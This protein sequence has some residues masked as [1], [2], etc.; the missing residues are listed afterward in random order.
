M[1]YR[2]FKFGSLKVLVT[3]PHNWAFGH[4]ALEMLMS[5]AMAKKEG[6]WVYF[7]QRTR[8][9]NRALFHLESDAVKILPR[10]LWIAWAFRTVWSI[11]QNA[12]KFI[13]GV[14]LSSKKIILARLGRK[15]DAS[16]NE[17]VGDNPGGYFRRFLIRDPVPVRLSVRERQE[18]VKQAEAMGISENTRVVGLHVREAGFRSRPGRPE[19]RS[20]ST[21][22]ARIE[23]YHKT[24]DYLVEQGCL[25]VRFGD[26]TMTPLI[27]HG[28][29]DLA[30]SARRTELLELH[31]LMKSEF[32]IACESGLLGVSYLVNIPLLNVNATDPVSSYPVRHDGLYILKRVVDRQTQSMLSLSDMVKEK[33]LSNLRNVERYEYIDNTSEEILDVT[34]EMVKNLTGTSE[35]SSAQREYKKLICQAADELRDRSGYVR[36]WGPEGGFWGDGW[37]GRC[38]AERNLYPG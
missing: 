29:V 37:I 2:W 14:W 26:P 25:I 15:I 28:V 13:E 16:Q 21:R 23:T 11:R 17:E 32:L 36:K 30:T 8:V 1:K 18:A 38:F 9:V 22:N 24:I 5:L 3:M 27:R 12:A 7:I 33:Y 4:L 31:C 19:H 35:P 20:M 34:R 6:A 10:S